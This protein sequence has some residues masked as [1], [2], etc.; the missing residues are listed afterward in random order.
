MT[1]D[2]FFAKAMD[3]IKSKGGATKQEKTAYQRLDKFLNLSDVKSTWANASNEKEFN[4]IFANKVIAPLTGSTC[5]IN[6][7]PNIMQYHE[8]VKLPEE[9]GLKGLAIGK[10]ILLLSSNFM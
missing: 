8:N 3:C 6:Y 1:L 5:I 7:K 2:V 9:H 4:A 10:K